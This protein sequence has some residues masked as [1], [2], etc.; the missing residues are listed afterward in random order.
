MPEIRPVGASP[1]TSMLIFADP[2][3]GKTTLVGT[4]AEAGLDIIIIRTPMDHIPARVLRSGAQ[5]IIVRDWDDMIG[6][7]GVLEY[8]QHQGHK[9]D[10]FWLDSIS[11][12]QDVGLGDVLQG[13]IDRKGP[14]RG[15][16]GPDRSEYRVNMWR[17]EQ[18]IRHMV[19][20]EG[21]NFGI[22]AHPFWYTDPESDMPTSQ[23]MPW[24]Q[25]KSMPQKICGY[26]N[27]VGF[28]EVKSRGKG[29][30][31]K[32]YRVIH[33]SKSDRY[34]AKDQYDA[35]GENGDIINPT[36]PKMMEAIESV[37]VRPKP[38]RRTRRTSRREQR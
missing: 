16:Y 27:V 5:E 35:F 26:M 17:E 10:W 22:T 32:K 9:H 37:R 29:A 8:A 18:F 12:F 11:L 33:T 7:D 38:Q 14:A 13:E 34:Y 28:M 1:K 36:L 21:F 24:I 20:A 23:L 30:Q 6:N 4:G 15:L 25:G 31:A 3:A 19:G 2:G